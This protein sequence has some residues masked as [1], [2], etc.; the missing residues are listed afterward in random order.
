MDQDYIIEPATN[1]AF[2]S[3]SFIVQRNVGNTKKYRL[4]TDYRNI[5]R[6]VIRNYQPLPSIE[7]VTS[8]W[9][10]CK[11]WSVADLH[12]AYHQINLKNSSRAIT[13]TSVPGV[14]YFQ[15]KRIPL[16]ISSAVGYFQGILE[17]ALLGIKNISCVNYLDDIASG[18]KTFDQMVTNL[19]KI[20]ERLSCSKV[21]LL[22]KPEKTK[23][24]QREIRYLGY[25]LTP[26]GIK[27]DPEKT[28]AV[29]KMVIPKNKKDVRS[30][31]GFCSFYRKFIKSY[32]DIVKPL[33]ELFKKDVKFHWGK[34]QQT[35]FDTIRKKL[36]EAPILQFPDLDKQFFLT[37]DASSTGIGCVL[38]QES[39]DGTLHPVAYASNLLTPTQKKWSSFQREF[40][41]LKF[42]CQKFKHFL[43][44]KKF[45]VRT[46]NQAL[47]NWQKFKDFDN[48]KL[49]RWFVTL[50]NYDFE[51]KFI[52]G[53]KN[54]SDGPSR[55]PRNDDEKLVDSIV[56]HTNVSHHINDGNV[57]ALVDSPTE[58]DDS[59][60]GNQSVH[61]TKASVTVI[62][63][64]Q[65]KLAQQNDETLK[66]VLSWV[67]AGEKP[68]LSRNIQKLDPVAKVYYNSYNRLKL[69]NGI[70]YRSWERIDN[71]KS[72]DLICIPQSFTEKIIKLCHDIPTGGHLGKPKTLSKIQSRF[73]W[74]KMELQISLYIDACEICIKK[75]QKQ[76]PVSPLQPFNGTHPGDIVQFDILENMPAN[77]QSYR[78]VLVIVDRFTCW[79]E[80]VPLKDTK[81]PTIAKCI[82]NNWIA[83]HGLPCQLHS[84]RGPQFTSE[85]MNIVYDLLGIIHLQLSPYE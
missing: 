65:L 54:E 9:A 76:K 81:A 27:V 33:T 29:T 32:S 51:V 43:M 2:H 48:P 79:V 35:A 1:S 53:C 18:A 50:A 36:V 44:G 6:H 26:S 40:Y 83:A 80:A 3:P 20:F 14:S 82:L 47:V 59:K 64:E 30:F 45:I 24:F 31:V 34:E 75:A 41:A 28:D 37:C 39:S 61:K 67:Q 46:D 66:L 72:D 22:L 85:V 84:D 49:W 5:N 10:G 68:Q 57:N 25:I 73:Y 21:G 63:E 74:P 8:I 23:L 17:Q 4:V 38:Q 62:D 71:E 11:F 13:A 77:S 56:T 16:G 15:F 7:T 58:S 78:S 42:Y 55:L 12:S 70:L 69:I 52:P 19:D 60:N